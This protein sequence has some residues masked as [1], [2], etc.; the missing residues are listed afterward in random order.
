MLYI[1]SLFC[2]EL[3]IYTKGLNTDVYKVLDILKSLLLMLFS[4]SLRKETFLPL[5]DIGHHNCFI[6]STTSMFLCVK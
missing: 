4:I 3:Y 6:L 2:K 1:C 5:T